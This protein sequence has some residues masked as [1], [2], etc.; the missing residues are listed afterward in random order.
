MRLVDSLKGMQREEDVFHCTP[1]SFLHYYNK[2][3]FD[4]E[5]IG[6]NV[7]KFTLPSIK[8]ILINYGFIDVDV[9]WISDFLSAYYLTKIVM[10]RKLV[11]RI[12]DDNAA[13]SNSPQSVE[14]IQRKLIKKADYVFVTGKNLMNYQE[15]DK[16]KFAYLPNGV[17]I[18]HFRKKFETPEEYKTITSP[19]VLFVGL[20]YDWFDKDL[21]KY[22]ASEL[23]DH[24]FI[25]VGS[26]NT[27]VSDLKAVKNIHFLGPRNYE[28]IPGYM[29]HADVG[30]IPFKVNQLTNSVS[31]IKLFEYFAAGLPVV[32]TD[33]FEIRQMRSPATLARDPSEFLQ[34]VV[35][36][37]RRKESRKQD[38][39]DFAQENS[40]D[41][42][43]SIVR[44]KVLST[45]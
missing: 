2:P 45:L 7:L 16:Q 10:Y 41:R 38:F 32:S 28:V 14:D 40:W 18:D 27:D 22:I 39:L 25:L 24:N 36:A 37:I 3:F 6:R 35:E 15:P 26:S 9:L 30:I 21:L 1:F 19:R 8:K 12:A 13:F 44:E 33:F 31:P 4:K 42:R 11:L 29:Q 17:D 43:F 23:P 5:W 34:A 20:I